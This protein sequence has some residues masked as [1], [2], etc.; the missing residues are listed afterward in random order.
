MRLRRNCRAFTLIEC[1][2]ATTILAIGVVGVASM[3]T[4]ASVS[5]RKATYMA[6]SR[7]IGD[8]IL[9]EARTQTNGLCQGSSGSQAVDT[10]GLPRSSGTV[11]WQP[12][13]SGAPDTGLKLVA[14]DISWSWPKPTAGEY[15]VLT[16]LYLYPQGGL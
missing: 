12:Y 16:L 8:R 2:V 13:P 5:Q 9:E 6:R 1:V 10:T 15:H 4:Y 7:E 3:F 11:A 14:V